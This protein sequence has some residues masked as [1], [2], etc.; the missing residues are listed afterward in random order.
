MNNYRLTS[1][2]T[3]EKSKRHNKFFPTMND[4]K[5]MKEKWLNDSALD[6]DTPLQGSNP[7]TPPPPRPMANSVG[8]GLQTPQVDSL[9]KKLV[10][11]SIYQHFNLCILFR[12][13]CLFLSLKVSQNRSKLRQGESAGRKRLIFLSPPPTC[14]PPSF[15]HQNVKIW[16]W[17]ANM[18]VQ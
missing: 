15:I 13:R 2:Q 5:L 17:K 16:C 6:G 18:G 3:L 10:T 11:P 7:A 9:L 14:P 4:Y 8:P 12:M 1:I